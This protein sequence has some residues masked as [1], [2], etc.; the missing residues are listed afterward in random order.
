LEGKELSNKNPSNQGLHILLGCTGTR[1][2]CHSG[3][4][5]SLVTKVKLIQ[6]ID[7]KEEFI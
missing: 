7:E 4:S 3:P 1:V 2:L 6:P 5:L